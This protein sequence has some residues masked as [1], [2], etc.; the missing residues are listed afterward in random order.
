MISLP[1]YPSPQPP[2]FCKPQCVSWMI[3]DI[4][5]VNDKN[6]QYIGD[7]QKNYRGGADEKNLAKIGLD[8]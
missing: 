6:I 4:F 2:P 5:H 8:Y 1:G 7:L 3:S